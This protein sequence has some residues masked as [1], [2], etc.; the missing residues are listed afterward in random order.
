LVSG[1]IFSSTRA[2]LS[3]RDTTRHG[4]QRAQNE[5][6]MDWGRMSEPTTSPTGGQ[7]R[8]RQGA[9]T[10]PQTRHDMT[11]GPGTSEKEAIEL[12]ATWRPLSLGV[13]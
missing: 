11:G 6:D 12:Q 4:L 13:K 5:H 3:A 2:L 10:G 8:Q 7:K 1:D 9:E